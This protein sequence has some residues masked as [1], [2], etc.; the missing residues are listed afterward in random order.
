MN[1]FARMN[2]VINY[3]EENITEEIDYETAAAIAC[4]SKNQFQRFFSYIT[5]ISLSEYIR[6]RRL[7]LSAFELQ[8]NKW[9]VIEIA[10]KYGYDSHASFTRAFREYHGISLTE[11]WNKGVVFTIFPKLTF[12]V[13]DFHLERGESNMAVLGK[14]EFADLPAV[15]MIGIKVINGGG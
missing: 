7:T 10:N 5:D 2:K 12:H 6:R 13:Q 14:I 11:A 8:Q 3:I 4:C 15:R 9:K 1:T